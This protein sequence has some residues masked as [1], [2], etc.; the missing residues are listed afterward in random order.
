MDIVNVCAYSSLIIFCIN[1]V[2]YSE[3]C[4]S[5]IETTQDGTVDIHNLCGLFTVFSKQK[6]RR[7]NS[8]IGRYSERD[9][10]PSFACSR[11]MHRRPRRH[12]TPHSVVFP[13]FTHTL[14]IQVHSYTIL[15][16][17]LFLPY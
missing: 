2:G 5:N 13:F 14:S 3:M 8:E 15:Y 17:Y 6:E 11:K 1:V 16:F 4:Y 10:S 7:R 9:M 12:P